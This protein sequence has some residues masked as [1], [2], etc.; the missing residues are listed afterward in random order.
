MSRRPR[1]AKSSAAG[2]APWPRSSASASSRTPSRA[3]P[4]RAGLRASGAGRA[5]ELR[6]RAAPAR[7]AP[8]W[9]CAS[10]GPAA[11]L[12]RAAR[13]WTGRR[14]TTSRSP[15][16]RRGSTPRRR[17][18]VGGRWLAA[19]GLASP[20]FGA[21]AQSERR[22]IA[23][24]T[25]DG[26][27]AAR[28]GPPSPRPREARRRPRARAQRPPAHPRRPPGRP[29]PLRPPPRER[30]PQRHR[31]HRR[32]DR[33]GWDRRGSDPMTVGSRL[34]R[35]LSWD[36]GPGASIA[37]DR[38]GERRRE[39]GR[40]AR[41]RRSRSTWAWT[42]TR[43]RSRW[44]PRAKEGIRE[45]RF[46][47]TT[48]NTPEAVCRLA[49]RLAGDPIVP[50]L[51]GR[52][53]RLRP[54]PAARRVGRAC[55]V[56][57]PSTMPRRPGERV[58]TDRRDATMLARLLRAGELEPVWI[59]DEGQDA[60]RDLVRAR[61][62]AKEDLTSACQSLL[63]FLLRHGRRYAVARKRRIRAFRRWRGEQAFSVRQQLVTGRAAEPGRALR[64]APTAFGVGPPLTGRV[65]RVAARP[66]PPRRRGIAGRPPLSL[67]RFGRCAASGSWGPRRWRPRSAASAASA[68][69]SGR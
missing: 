3:G 9:P 20:V 12:T 26:L 69:P 55:R 13:P 16:S 19:G 29:G 48:A 25:R 28:R 54:A 15:R 59:S 22:A 10:I 39:R 18:V 8:S 65:E 38:G 42:C 51:R 40:P 6:P 4:G 1:T 17:P 52:P 61:R 23:Q 31:P 11:R 68:V 58:E 67:G 57:A 44:R 37:G 43:T 49:S 34:P 56:I 62:G 2:S 33:R 7:A 60:V 36:V 53:V 41:R 64:P 35:S 14:A 27:R 32:R 63:S 21:I 46:P 30:R 50:V 5:D 24:R 47:G 66:R 45:V